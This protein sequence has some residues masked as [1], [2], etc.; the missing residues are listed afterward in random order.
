MAGGYPPAAAL[1]MALT[2]GGQLGKQAAQLLVAG[3]LATDPGALIAQAAAVA[4]A[5]AIPA[6]PT[7]AAAAPAAAQ[8]AEVGPAKQAP[9]VAVSRGRGKSRSKKAAGGVAAKKAKPAKRQRR[10]KEASDVE[11]GEAEEYE[12]QNLPSPGNESDEEWRPG[13]CS[14]GKKRGRRSRR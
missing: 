1:A 7:A 9:E 12:D 10:R 8:A 5:P 4:Q 11:E 6:A 3:T 13:K 14:V 2:K